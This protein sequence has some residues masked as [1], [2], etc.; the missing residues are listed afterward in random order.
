[1]SPPPVTP[2]PHRFV[3]KNP[4]RP[5]SSQHAPQSS[6]PQFKATPRFSF[7]ASQ[8]AGIIG[9]Q[10]AVNTP[11]FNTAASMG[12]SGHRGKDD[13]QDDHVARLNERR[14]AAYADLHSQTWEDDE[15]VAFQSP[16]LKRRRLSLEPI[17]S[18]QPCDGGNYG[19]TNVDFEDEDE[20]L[21][22][23]KHGHG[24]DDDFE[25]LLAMEPPTL[26]SPP[27]P[28]YRPPPSAPRFVLSTPSKPTSST[29]A[30][31]ESADAF[32]RP[33][34]FKPPDEEREAA[35]EPLPE[36]FSPR[37]RG[38]KFLA[39]GLAAEVR[40]WLVDRE[41]QA[42]R[43]ARNP[44][45]EDGWKIKIAVDEVTGGYGAGMTLVR[46]RRVGS[47]S[48]EGGGVYPIR[49]MLGGEEGMSEGIRKGEQAA[50]GKVVGVKGPAW[51]V[52]VDAT[53]LTLTSIFL[54]NW[55]TID[56]PISPDDRLRITY[57][58]HRACSS[59][60]NSCRPFPSSTDCLAPFSDGPNF[61]TIWRSAAFLMSFTG[62]LEIVTLITFG[63]ILA[64]GLQKRAEGWKVLVG[65]MGVVV[66]GQVASTA[67]IAYLLDY[68]E[69]FFPGWELGQ[70]WVMGT[71]SW[72]VVL[73]TA[74]GVGV[75]SYLL[76]L[77]GG[78][79]L[80]PSERANN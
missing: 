25:D 26:S 31:I 64:G 51:E 16:A 28:A 75:A 58:L 61:C 53:V 79:E 9:S 14:R 8:G 36:H 19:D 7:A 49:M 1:M 60:T 43:S 73:C 67:M 54:P 65:L 41:S 80:I 3:I 2:S 11:R 77:E 33:P 45:R 18:S 35:V 55:L 38:Q 37:R 44:V 72:A 5:A 76:P 21:D 78:Y 6:A 12:V 63:I 48:Y 47:N 32:L 34:R 59:L 62:I 68:D 40:G 74:G 70:S 20:E 13:E 57:G 56:S 66:L 15:E 71:V 24:M 39:G 46:G 69:R 22:Q 27:P 30:P 29:P 10:H 50:V 23:Q 52:D 17:L 42:A 4:S